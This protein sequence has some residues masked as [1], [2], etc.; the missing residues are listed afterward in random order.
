M[1]ESRKAAYRN[2]LYWSFLEI[3]L[4]AAPAWSP[5]V[6]LNP[7]RL[8]KQVK[9][10]RKQG[11]LASW[12]HNLASY[13][14]M[15][16]RDFDEKL[17]WLGGEDFARYDP[18]AVTRYRAFFEQALT[19]GQLTNADA[20]LEKKV[21]KINGFLQAFEWFNNKTDH[22]YSFYS[23]SLGVSDANGA[24]ETYKQRTF[25]NP[26]E[27]RTTKKQ[28]EDDWKIVL[29]RLLGQ[30]LFQFH[31]NPVSNITLS[32]RKNDFSLSDAS[33]RNEIVDDL[34]KW[35]E[36]ISTF[37]D[38][39]EVEFETSA[40]YEVRYDDLLLVGKDQTLLVHLGQSD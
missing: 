30:W 17:F 23:V 1:N 20:R 9:I 19:D 38:V 6:W 26:S 7:F 16:F 27:V 18:T 39:F 25:K 35:F 10:L 29:A 32:D 8:I 28:R 24:L 34:I 5:G 33:F 22:G 2:L 21:A 36:D 40:F 3:R 4:H 11:A 31:S 37:H 13:S 14:S 15:D 12:M